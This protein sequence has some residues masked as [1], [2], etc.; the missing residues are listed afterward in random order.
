MNDGGEQGCLCHQVTAGLTAENTPTSSTSTT[1]AL[2]LNGGGT[3][4]PSAHTQDARWH[5]AFEPGGD[6][7]VITNLKWNWCVMRLRDRHLW[8]FVWIQKVLQWGIK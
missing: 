2:F 4:E 6:F 5:V 7:I 3:S 8:H 1:S